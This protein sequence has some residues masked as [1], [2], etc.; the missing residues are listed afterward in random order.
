MSELDEFE[1]I[2]L[3]FSNDDDWDDIILS[4]GQDYDQS[5]YGKYGNQNKLSSLL[6][7]TLRYKER[8]NVFAAETNPTNTAK[9]DTKQNKKSAKDKPAKPAETKSKPANAKTDKTDTPHT[10]KSEPQKTAET[11]PKNIEKSAPPKKKKSAKGELDGDLKQINTEM[12]ED[13]AIKSKLNGF[14]QKTMDSFINAAE[15]GILEFD[16]KFDDKTVEF[17]PLFAIKTLTKFPKYKKCV[18]FKQLK[19]C[20]DVDIHKR[21]IHVIVA[22]PRLEEFFKCVHNVQA[23]IGTPLWKQL[24]SIAAN[25]DL[26]AEDSDF[27]KKYEKDLNVALNDNFN[28][29]ENKDIAQSDQQWADKNAENRMLDQILKKTHPKQIMNQM[30]NVEDGVVNSLKKQ[31]KKGNSEIFELFQKL[32][33]DLEKN[34]EQNKKIMQQNQQMFGQFLDQNNDANKKLGRRFKRFEGDINGQKKEE[35]KNEK[36]FGKIMDENNEAN[37]KLGQR[38]KDFKGD[39]KKNEN[40]EQKNEALF[41]KFLSQNNKENKKLNEKF[42]TFEGDLSKERGQEKANGKLISDFMAKNGAM[43]KKLNDKLK[44]FSRDVKSEKKRIANLTTAIHQEQQNPPKEI[45]KIKYKTKKVKATTPMIQKPGIKPKP[46]VKQVPMKQKPK[47]NQVP[48]PNSKN[49]PRPK[50]A[51]IPKPNTARP[52][53]PIQKNV[54][55]R[56]MYHNQVTHPYNNYNHGMMH[57][58]MYNHHPMYHHPMHHMMNGY[59]MMHHPYHH[60]MHHPYMMHHPMHTMGMMGGM[61]MNPMMNPMGM[62]GMGTHFVLFFYTNIQIGYLF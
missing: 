25:K 35:Q 31:F 48:K 52:Q 12:N 38:F 60:P 20:I 36:L 49:V 62:M 47:N 34:N 32:T 11:K 33:S 21:L 50:V 54:Q 30:Q 3:Y 4:E 29:H 8:D 37:K 6:T 58:P 28:E 56:P 19:L 40:Q 26:F 27:H 18:N 61:G 23:C 15:K 44:H 10:A 46:K 5:E 59:G 41:S 57:H 7:H 39:I 22:I 51:T 42:K 9:S 17:S 53:V 13:S 2:V 1:D 43:S 55:R 16:Y 45:V 14:A 24:Q